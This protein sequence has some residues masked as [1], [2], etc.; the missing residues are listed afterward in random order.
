M[1][2]YFAP[3]FAQH[4]GGVAVARVGWSNIRRGL[5]VETHKPLQRPRRLTRLLES[6]IQ[7]ISQ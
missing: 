4:R 5:G 2:T 6:D 7:S 3:A 1:T